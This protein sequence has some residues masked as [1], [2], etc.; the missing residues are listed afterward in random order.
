MDATA[1]RQRVT[2][3]VAVVDLGSTAV[4]F[5]LARIAPGV[6]YR[7]LMQERVETRL[8]D[9]APGTLSRDAI[10]ETLRAVRRFVSRHASDGGG[11]RIVAVATAAV[12]DAHNRERLLAPLRRDEG[13]EVRILSPRAEARLGVAAAMESLPFEEGVVADLGGSS[14][15]LSRV[16][17]G[18]VLSVASL[19]LG[20]VRATRRF[21]RHDPP[22]PRELRAFRNGIRAA[23]LGVM[24]P[25][26]RGEVMVGLGGTIRTLAGIH[27][28]AHR[29]ERRRRHGL[30]LHQSD[31]TA[32]RERLEAVSRRKRSK[33]RGL[34]RER[35]DI[36]LAGAIVIE[37][38][39]V[40]GGYLQL[41][42]CTRGV[43]DG[44]LLRET[45][46]GRHAR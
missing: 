9:G 6:G 25:A 34:K 33:I 7:V 36:I 16:R 45:F 29:G 46:N 19:P 24:P 13:I 31:V 38:A 11:P 12:R 32:I 40:F 4:R 43:G 20:V 39:M 8:G 10:D 44:I 22:T 28:G 27:L 2:Q 23:M 42:V 5:R 30:R 3:L 18:K 35:A 21:L 14:L 17:H 15:Q 37:E 1:R 26:G 41:V